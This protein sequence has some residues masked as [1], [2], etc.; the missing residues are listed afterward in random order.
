MHGRKLSRASH[1]S[2]QSRLRR[3]LCVA[4]Q[5]EDY[6]P[7]LDESPVCGGG[8]PLL[9]SIELIDEDP[10]QPRREFDPSGLAE[11]AATIATRGVRQPVSVRRHPAAPDRWMLNFG[12]RRLRASKLAGMGDIPAFVD[13][14]AD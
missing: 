14:A 4:L 7:A 2:P 5:L 6:L 3:R 9:L 8:R 1:A 13:E 12:A 11:L 10:A